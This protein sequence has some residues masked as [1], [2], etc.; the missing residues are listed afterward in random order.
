MSDGISKWHDDMDEWAAIIMDAGIRDVNWDC[1]S[2]EAKYA[3]EGYRKQGLRGGDL[4]LYVK[5]A[6]ARDLLKQQQAEEKA[7]YKLYL[8]LKQKYEPGE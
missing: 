7:E 3:K 5:Q 4:K 1:Y 2:D 6:L 8:K